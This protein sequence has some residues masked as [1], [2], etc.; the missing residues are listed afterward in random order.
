MAA[1]LLSV[2][3]CYNYGMIWP[4]HNFTGGFHTIDFDYSERDRERYR[5]L[6]ELAGLIPGEAAVLASETLAPHV[7]GRHIVETARFAAQRRPRQYDYILLHD[8]R[9]VQRLRQVPYL[10][11]LRGYDVVRRGEFFVLFKQ[12]TS[13]EPPS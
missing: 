11:G 10:D 1:V 7:A 2:I 5:E 13:E 9:S 3:T 8:N 12:R 4:R 6:R